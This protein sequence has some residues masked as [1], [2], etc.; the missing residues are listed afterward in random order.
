VLFGPVLRFPKC[1][2]SSSHAQAVNYFSSSSFCLADGLSANPPPCSILFRTA[3]VNPKGIRFAEKRSPGQF[4]HLRCLSPISE[5]RRFAYL[6]CYLA[7]LT[8]SSKSATARFAATGSE[9]S[10][11]SFPKPEYN[12]SKSITLSSSLFVPSLPTIRPVAL[13]PCS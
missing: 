1:V 13:A 5:N 12:V 7:S 3:D 8:A 4:H 10:R 9:S 11:E 2:I 6:N